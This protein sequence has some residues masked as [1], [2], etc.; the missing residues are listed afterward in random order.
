V[1]E[2]ARD[3]VE[4]FLASNEVSTRNAADHEVSEGPLC[5]TPS[6]SFLAS[7]RPLL[8]HLHCLLTP[9][10]THPILARERGLIRTPS[11]SP[12]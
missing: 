3:R 2:L 6:G 1:R 10:P 9:E 11:R 4:P 5:E 7:A 12:E 8:R